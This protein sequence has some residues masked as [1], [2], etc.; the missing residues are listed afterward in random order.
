MIDREWGILAFASL[1]DDADDDVVEESLFCE[2]LAHDCFY[3]DFLNEGSSSFYME[4]GF[5]S[6]RMAFVQRV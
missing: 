5:L 4:M 1:D 6:P 2:G 3:R